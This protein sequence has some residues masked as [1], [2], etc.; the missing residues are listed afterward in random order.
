M[1]PQICADCNLRMGGYYQSFGLAGT[2]VVMRC[3]KCKQEIYGDIDP[4][5]IAE[6]EVDYDDWGVEIYWAGASASIHEIA[7]LRKLDPSLRDRSMQT[8]LAEIR[9]APNWRIN[10]LSYN[11][12]TS[13]IWELRRQGISCVGSLPS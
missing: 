10:N 13:I 11:Q 9:Q 4:N 5:D 12:C 6:I 3:H 8:C 2:R 1:E 7:M